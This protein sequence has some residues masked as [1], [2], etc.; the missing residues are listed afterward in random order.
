MSQER[1]TFRIREGFEPGDFGA[2]VN[3]HGTI[4]AEEYQLDTSF[5]VYVA[6]PLAA[7]ARDRAERGDPAG[8]IWLVEVDPLDASYGCL[9]IVGACALVDGGPDADLIRWV[10]LDQAAR[11]RGLG[12]ELIELMIAKARQRGKR[13]IELGTFH[14]LDAAIDLYRRFG[15][16]VT[17][18]EREMI[19]G[20]DLEIIT[21]TL[22][23]DES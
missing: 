19:W 21:M 17:K 23:F 15:F 10:I 13:R 14:K 5:E 8:H 11:G 7:F 6:E 4:Y 9:G 16:E 3:L 1:V 20:Q 12:R 18:R 22:E 2:V